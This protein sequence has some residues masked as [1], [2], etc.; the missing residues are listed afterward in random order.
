METKNRRP[1]VSFASLSGFRLAPAG[2]E[3][4]LTEL[5]LLSFLVG[6]TL[7]V[8]AM[9]ARSAVKN[10]IAAIYLGRMGTL[11][12]L[13][14]NRSAPVANYQAGALRILRP[15][16]VTITL[17][18]PTFMVLGLLD[19]ATEALG[20]LRGSPA[21]IAVTATA[22]LS[23]VLLAAWSLRDL[24]C[25][26]RPIEAERNDGP[27]CL[28]VHRESFEPGEF[29]DLYVHAP[30][31]C[32]DL[33]IERVVPGN[34]TLM[35]SKALQGRRQAFPG[36]AF[37]RPLDWLEPVS[38]PI[39]VDW[40]SGL[41]RAV[42]NDSATRTSASF[43]IRPSREHRQRVVVL[44]N[45]NT[46]AAYNAWGGASL[47]AYNL[48]DGSDRQAATEVSTL[49]PNPS[50]DV[51][52]VRGHLAGGETH[53]LRWLEQ[54]SI[55][56][57]MVAD[58]DLHQDAAALEGA[59]VLILNTHPE[60]WTAEMLDAVVAFLNQGGSLLAL[61]GNSMYWRTTV[62]PSTIEVQKY[63]GRHRMDGRRGGTWTRLGRS[64]RAVLGVSHTAAGY[65]TYA[66]YVVTAPDHWLFEGTG[67]THGDR[68]GMRSLVTA[69]GEEGASGWETDKT[70]KGTPKHAVTIARGEQ[71]GGAEMVYSQHHAGGHVLAAGSITSASAVPVCTVLGRIVKN[72][73][74]RSDVQS[75]INP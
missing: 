47:Y 30:E 34:S 38:V 21:L 16:L 60:Y 18:G 14:T 28:Y 72:F 39:P 71:D 67:V 54:S 12:R 20:L 26:E 74:A 48:R 23:L 27:L 10:V 43:V 46:W 75:N 53:L 35:T 5:Q 24:G 68:F 50:A 32:F 44:A 63:R 29:M 42:V 62:S 15:Y 45:T 73:L 40:P 9:G 64:E 66:P 41:Y 51:S 70:G 56:F 49:R 13:I 58:R 19:V 17:A 36:C 37:L 52:D 65:N 59:T 1:L 69:T 25:L 3:S 4:T 57:G 55:D 31:E 7:T 8:G 11:N 2:C 22:A 33:A 61:S 6:A